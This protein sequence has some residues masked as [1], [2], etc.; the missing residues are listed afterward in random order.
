MID[1]Y[2][3]KFFDMMMECYGV[4][5]WIY[6]DDLEVLYTT[7]ESPN[8]Y[9]VLLLGKGRKEAILEHYSQKDSP[10]IVSD[11]IGLMWGVVKN[12]RK[13][14]DGTYF[15]LGPILNKEPTP[16][17]WNDLLEPLS[18]EF[19]NKWNLISNLKYLPCISIIVFF[20]HVIILSYYVNQENIRTSNFDYYTTRQVSKKKANEEKK[21]KAPHASPLTEKKLLDMVRTGNLDYHKVLAEAGVAS[22]GIR[23]D[24]SDPIRQ[25]KYSVVAFITLCTRAAIEGGLSSEMAYTLSDTYIQSVDNSHS[26]SQVAAVSHTMYEDFIRRVNRLHNTEGVS[27]AVRDSCDYIDVHPEEEIT[28]SFLSDKVGY[29]ENYLGRKFKAEMH[30]PINAYLRK[31]RVEKAK[32]LLLFTNESIQDIADELH[33]CSQSYFAEAFRKETGLSPLE[34]RDKNK[35][36]STE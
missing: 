9:K 30:M 12:K 25:A 20:Q 5:S 35:K 32:M 29:S 23:V 14:D 31:A 7:S 13:K 22:P 36:N 6:D 27:K 26:V 3:Q 28:L 34:Y 11:D 4:S 1:T 16:Q 21:G 8:L 17:I 24:S 33:F 15:I 18:L 19:S 2:I 10:L